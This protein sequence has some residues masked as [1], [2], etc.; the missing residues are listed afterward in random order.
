MINESHWCSLSIIC[1][2]ESAH[3]EDHEN[4]QAMLVGIIDQTV[5]LLLFNFLASVSLSL[6]AF[7]SLSFIPFM[8][9]RFQSTFE[10]FFL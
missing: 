5:R 10:S 1:V 7:I 2:A 6:I 4:Y 9:F 8:K 3:R